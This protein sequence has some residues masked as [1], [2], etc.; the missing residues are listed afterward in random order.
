M[1]DQIEAIS[2]AIDLPNVDI[3]IIPFSAQAAGIFPRHGFHLYDSDAVIWGSESG[4]ATISDSE[5]I[6]KYERMFARLADIALVGEAARPALDHIA[7][8]YR[9]LI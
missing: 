7:S 9:S 4:T 5:D 2:T 8:D 6:S 1:L 3:G